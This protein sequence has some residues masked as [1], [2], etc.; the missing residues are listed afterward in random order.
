MGDLDY[1]NKRKEKNNNNKFNE[2]WFWD[3][4]EKKHNIT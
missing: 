1:P 2:V 4:S 3:N